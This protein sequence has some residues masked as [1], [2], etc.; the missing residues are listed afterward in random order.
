MKNYVLIGFI[1]LCF[2]AQSQSVEENIPSNTSMVF[3]INS[4]ALTKAV[5]FDELE[6]S[7]F[8]QEMIEELSKLFEKEIKSFD[9]IGIRTTESSYIF[10]DKENA[11]FNLV[12]LF[13]IKDKALIEKVMEANRFEIEDLGSHYAASDPSGTL[14]FWNDKLL[15]IIQNLEGNDSTKPVANYLSK[16]PKSILSNA[17]YKKQA[18]ENATFSFWID[19]ISNSLPEIS[20]ILGNM[21]RELNDKNMSSLYKG[22]ES[23]S[24]KM[25]LDATESRLTTE[26]SFND[27]ISKSYRSIFNQKINASFFE[28][29]DLKNCLGYL[30][31]NVNVQNFLTEY[32]AILNN[33]LM[34]L[35]EA[36][37]YKDEID[38]GMVLFSTLLDEEAVGNII[39]G[40]MLFV[41]SDLSEKEVEYTTYEYDSNYQSVPIKKTKLEKVPDFVYM[42]SVKE[43]KLSRA[44]INYLL[45]KEQIE[46]QGGFY[47]IALNK[48]VPVDLFMVIKNDILFLGTSIDRFRAISTGTY[49]ANVPGDFKNHINNNQ[50]AFYA[51][52][53]QATTSISLSDFASEKSYMQ[54]KELIEGSPDVFF[55]AEKFKKNTVK[56]NLVIK[57]PK[58]FSS[59]LTYLLHVFEELK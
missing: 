2:T 42:A 37:E 54:A 33:Q 53:R 22:Y 6:K 35:P 50:V 45:T 49:K 21:S 41:L 32:P 7:E 10:L 4:P 19:D 36:H 48:S 8:G 58:G 25:Y 29:T 23:L 46:D 9:E 11:Q 30:S 56:G 27:D 15:T 39:K 47:K 31:M 38:L 28:Y 57:T 18:D 17:S 44:T 3:E 5:P 24:M 59:G 16:A 52:I 14:F 55:T 34:A 26:M 12:F 51:G 1:L 13:P 43:S 40:D 20:G